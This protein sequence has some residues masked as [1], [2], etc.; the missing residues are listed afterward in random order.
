MNTRL[1]VLADESAIDVDSIIQPLFF[2]W[3]HN[4]NCEM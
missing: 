2:S 4:Q 1:V 3:E